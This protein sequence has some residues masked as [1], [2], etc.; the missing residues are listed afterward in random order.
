[1]RRFRFQGL[2]DLIQDMG[3]KSFTIL[4]DT[5]ESLIQ[6]QAVLKLHGPDDMP[7]TIRQLDP[8]DDHRTL[9]KEIQMSGESHIILHCR[10]DRVLTVLR[11]AKEVKLMEDYQSYV[12]THLVSILA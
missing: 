8:F 5:D 2:A 9:L 12:I 7:I 10:P 1:M 11:Q 4:Y 6:L 3:W